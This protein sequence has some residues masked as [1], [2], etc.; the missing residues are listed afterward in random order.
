MRLPLRPQ[1]HLSLA[2][3]AKPP[4]P[5]DLPAPADIIVHSGDP[6]AVRVDEK[7]GA[8]EI[9]L[10]DG[11]VMI[12]LGGKD[13][14]AE[15]GDDFSANLAEVLG[16]AELNLMAEDLLRGIQSDDE[17][18]SSWLQTRAAGIDILGLKLEQPRGDVG[19]SSAPLEGMATVRHPLLLEAVLRFQAT[20]RGELLA[21]TG[22]VKVRNDG[23]ETAPS[24]DLAEKLEN[25]MNHYLTSVA[26]EYYPDTDRM[27]F[28]VGFG[29]CGFKKVYNCPIRRRPVSESVDAKDIIISNAATDLKNAGR[30]THQITMRPSVLKRMQLAGAYRDVELTQ[31]T[32]EPTEVDEKIAAVQG[33]RAKPER[34]EDQSYTINECYCELNIDGYEHKQ[35]GKITGLPLPYRVVIEKDSRKV[36]EIRRNWNEDDEAC[37]AKQALV[38]YPFVPGLGF[39]DIGLLHILGNSANALTAAWRLM[40]DA[41]MYACF[42]GFLYA[43]GGSRQL[44]NEFRIA[45]GSGMALETGGNPIQQMVMPLPYRDIT[46]GLAQLTQ[47]IDQTSQRVGGTAET[48][49]GEG[50]QETP[51]GTTLALIEQATKIQD[52]VHKR[53]HAAQAEE[54]QMLKE[55]FREDPESFWRHNK[56]ASNWDKDQFIQ[57]LNNC[58]L[59]PAA[60]PNTPSHMHRIMKAV[61]VKQMQQANPEL[62]NAKEVDTR[63]LKMIGWN[64]PESLFAAPQM[65]AAAPP[66]PM[67]AIKQREIDV[68]EMGMRMDMVDNE[69]ERDSKEDIA[70]LNLAKEIAIHAEN[71]A[72]SRATLALRGTGPSASP[73]PTP[74]PAGPPKPASRGGRIF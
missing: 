5:E 74:A 45:P 47:N 67:I 42:P 38:K 30:V 29:G 52:A 60:D 6:D 31:P 53:L 48:M 68:K 40:L 14:D 7:T 61:A 16:D 4:E 56:N 39:Y 36:L 33:V 70:V 9:P 3:F 65:P 58:N 63:I 71:A 28:Y 55:C 44:S 54:F 11:S 62:Y 64:D 17:S 26:T 1:G 23:D 43:K 35:D 22:P 13:D 19:A 34:P 10:P 59:V 41:G 27:L 49:V 15:N 37:L 50:V 18:R 2:D 25:D 24:G 46:P 73:M 20:A 32:P 57:A 21:S 69:R 72:Q 8:I 51:V 66:D 12:D